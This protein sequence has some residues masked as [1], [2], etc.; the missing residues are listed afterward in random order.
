VKI[1]WLGWDYDRF[2][3]DNKRR[4]NVQTHTR[5]L[6][7]Q[8]ALD[9]LGTIEAYTN[10]ELVAIE[11]SQPNEMTQA[12]FAAIRARYEPISAAGADQ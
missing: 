8:D 1:T 10:M 11:L 2:P 4:I 6:F 7:G 12:A 5:E 3:V 9:Q